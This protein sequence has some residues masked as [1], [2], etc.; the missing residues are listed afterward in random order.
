MNVIV[1]DCPMG[2]AGDM[3]VGALLHV[4]IPVDYLEKEIKKLKLKGYELKLRRVKCGAFAA[5]KFDVKV[6]NHPTHHH[7]SLKKIE[8]II[9]DSK[10]TSGAKNIATRIFKNLGR[11]EAKVH[12]IGLQKVHFHE[13]GAVD[14]IIDIVGTAV[15]FDYLQIKKAYVRTLKI[16]RGMQKGAHGEM[17]VPVPATYELLKGFSLTQTEDFGE[18]ITPTGAAILA[19]LCQKESKIPSIRFSAIGYGAGDRK[20]KGKRGF[21]RLAVGST[22]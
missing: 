13:V 7:T 10:L 15:C 6:L 16:G 1:F 17:P 21:L 8:E 18:K 3:T 19:T 22:P 12:G 9:K 11:A 14:S 4:G 20:F 2:I 5:R